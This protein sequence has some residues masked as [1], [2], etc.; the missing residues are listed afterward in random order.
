M[1]SFLKRGENMDLLIVSGMS[2]SGKSTVMKALEDLGY[3]CIDNFPAS[4]LPYISKVVQSHRVLNQHVAITIDIRSLEVLDDIPGIFKIL[5]EEEIS[6]QTLFLDS[7]NEILLRRFKETRRNHPLMSSAKIDL[8]RAIDLEREYMSVIKN[9]S[10][11]NIDTSLD[12]TAQL[13]QKVNQLFGDGDKE[14]LRLN[15]VSFGFKHGILQDADLLF[16]V[17]CLKNPYYE[18][19]LRE[20]TGLDQEVRDYVMS[21][22]AAK[23]LFE[24]ILSYLKFSLPLYILEGKSQLVVGIACTGGK[25]RSV[26]FA[27]LLA[28]ALE[29]E[30]VL[31]QVHHRDILR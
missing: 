19:E 23:G 6:Y 5:E 11:F 30:D 12:G 28:E 26:T 22:D 25:H 4:L 21:T 20:K 13:K 15:V 2:G 18:L 24:H 10:N 1:I 17:R 31:V 8:E 29:M 14:K 16:D 9:R 27:K 3:F 7:S